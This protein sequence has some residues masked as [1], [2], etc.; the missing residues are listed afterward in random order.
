MAKRW[1]S[2]RLRHVVR[3][4]VRLNER[5]QGC[6]G[7]WT[8]DH[9][10]TGIRY[11]QIFLARASRA[12]IASLEDGG[13]ISARFFDGELAAE[14][15][16]ENAAFLAV[17]QNFWVTNEEL[18]LGAVCDLA[19]KR[20]GIGVGLL[21]LA[22]STGMDEMEV[23]RL[24]EKLADE[25]FLMREPPLLEEGR[26]YAI[27][28]A[29]IAAVE[30]QGPNMPAL[31]QHEGK[32]AMTSSKG[33][34][35]PAG[36]EPDARKV[37]VVHGRNG[38]A[39]DAM[40]SFL[41]A[42]GLK[43]IE[44]EHAVHLSGE[45]SPYIGQALDAAFRVAQAVVVI[46]TG[47]DEARLLPAFQSPRDPAYEKELTPQ[48]R[49][50]VL[51]EA[52]MAFG[53][54]PRRTIMVQIGEHMRPFSDVAGRHLIHFDGSDKARN[55]LKS[56]LQ[57]AGCDADDHGGDWLRAGDFVTALRIGSTSII[58]DAPAPKA[59]FVDADGVSWNR[60]PDGTFEQWA[61]C[62]K[63]RLAMTTFP[64]GSNEMLLCSRCN[65]AAPFRPGEIDQHRPR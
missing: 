36:V 57:T 5:S 13:Y 9:E 10:E 56:R 38:A 15:T 48:A 25:K 47:D 55:A 60:K 49:P 52:G 32:A 11:G 45:G 41:Q 63:C 26:G 54:N 37:F 42:L 39:R 19:D 31:V 30:E 33:Q 58:A 2:P 4:L 64:P 44:W 46:L 17:H 29:G 8:K 16:V 62:P 23:M 18:L 61:Y 3:I 22:S 20:A 6:N 35:E 65:F 59:G 7:F 27:T 21:R 12:D 51:F 14:I 1:L 34:Q 24:A 28:R 53:Y 40:F 50:N 43:P